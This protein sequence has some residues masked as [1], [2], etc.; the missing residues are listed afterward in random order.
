MQMINISEF[1]ANLL[2]Y[3]EAANAGQLISVTSNGRLLATITPPQNQRAEAKQQLSMIA[4]Q[5][6]I[7]DVISPIES[8]WDAQQ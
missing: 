6:Q 4:E 8:D 1:R 5:A 2:S 7:Y 3:L